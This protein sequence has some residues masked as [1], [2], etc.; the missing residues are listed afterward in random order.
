MPARMSAS[1]RT[2][3]AAT[4]KTGGSLTPGRA[5]ELESMLA[6]SER[7]RDELSWEVQRER[8]KK[9]VV[10]RDLAHVQAV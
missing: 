4:Q 9:E 7:A 1:S 8:A 3:A 10:E 5:G 2:P 6:E